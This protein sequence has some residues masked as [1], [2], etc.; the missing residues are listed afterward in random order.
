[1]G[2]VSEKQAYREELLL[3]NLRKKNKMSTAEVVE[4]LNISES[5]ARRFFDEL[6]KKGSIIRI[7]GGIKLAAEPIMEYHFNDAELR[8]PEEKHRIAE[9]AVSFVNNGDIIYIDN[10][11]TLHNFASVLSSRLQS[12]QLSDIHV[13]T[14]ALTNLQTLAG[15]CDINLIGGF[16]RSKRQDFCGHL[17]EMVL[18][19]ISFDKCF[20]G[21]DGIS[22][23]TKDGIMT[24]DIYTAKID[25]ILISRTNKTFLLTDSTKFHHRS[26]IKYASI[27]D[28]YMII[29]DYQLNND[30]YEKILNQHVQIERV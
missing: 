17:T 26:F 6:E 18:E 15:F 12:G 14:N 16:Y 9:F 20:L 11:T 13:Y 2:I 24:T 1:M 22:L 21:A 4:L 23:D 8:Q 3:S 19:S 28:P 7:Y 10:G 29:T 5:T 30:I 25:E 27:H